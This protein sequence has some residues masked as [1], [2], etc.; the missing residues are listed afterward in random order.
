M[1]PNP[2]EELD[3][4]GLARLQ[5]LV[6]ECDARFVAAL[7][8]SRHLDPAVIAAW[9]GGMFT[10]PKALAAGL[11]DSLGSLETAIALAASMAGY[12]E[13]RAA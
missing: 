6:G 11:A 5:E 3:A 1:N 10:G 2:A 8:A 9:N 12:Q 7:S 4:L 13:A